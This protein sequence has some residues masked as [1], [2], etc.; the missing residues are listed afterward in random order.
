MVRERHHLLFRIVFSVYPC[1][2]CGLQVLSLSSPCPPCPLSSPRRVGGRL[3]SLLTFRERVSAP[4]LS[5][6]STVPA[7]V[8]RAPAG[9]WWLGGA[10][11]LPLRGV[12]P[13]SG[14]GRLGPGCRPCRAVRC[15]LCVRPWLLLLQLAVWCCIVA[16]TP[17]A[18]VCRMPRRLLA[19]GDRS[20]ADL[21][22]PCTARSW[23]MAPAGG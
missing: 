4:R 10:L 7:A 17:S 5:L 19:A 20:R 3:K 14:S 16:V 2:L 21:G 6:S 22:R 11:R 23:Q 18:D 8:D 12:S 1:P 9:R 15:V 13:G